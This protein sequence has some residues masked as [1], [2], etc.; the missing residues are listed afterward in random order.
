[1]PDHQPITDAVT[2]EAQ[3]KAMQPQATT[4]AT[5]LAAQI[6]DTGA[7]PAAPA[8]TVPD[9]NALHDQLTEDLSVQGGE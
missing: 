6:D 8:G 2:D 5:P 7:K 9:K 4:G 1:M 3:R